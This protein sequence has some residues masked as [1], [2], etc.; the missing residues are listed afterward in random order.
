MHN[1]TTS[2][3]PSL[4]LINGYTRVVFGAQHIWAPFLLSSRH[5]AGTFFLRSAEIS[6]S[7]FP[8]G[9]CHCSAGILASPPPPGAPTFLRSSVD[10]EKEG[11]ATWRT[12]LDSQEHDRNAD[13]AWDGLGA[14]REGAGSA[15]PNFGLRA[16]AAQRFFCL[17]IYHPCSSWFKLSQITTIAEKAAD[18]QRMEQRSQSLKLV[19]GGEFPCSHSTTLN[20][21]Q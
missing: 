8:K 16:I 12:W 5:E 10:V 7:S 3:P 20:L 11:G 18:W 14:A 2:L 21:L 17:F 1:I 19:K 9:G 6:T 4:L 13:A 15:F